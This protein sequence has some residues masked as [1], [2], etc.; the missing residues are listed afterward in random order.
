MNPQHSIRL[1][2]NKRQAKKSLFFSILLLVGF[3]FMSFPSENFIIRQL[4]MI[5]AVYYLISSVFQLRQLLTI[6]KPLIEI[7]AQ[8]IYERT[9]I[10][11]LN[12]IMWS[13]IEAITISGRKQLWANVILFHPQQFIQKQPSLIARLSMRYLKSGSFF[14]NATNTPIKISLENISIPSQNAVDLIE[15]HFSHY[16]KK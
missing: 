15:S 16:G 12:K 6:S 14:G 3:T 8:G 13:E 2:L 10:A 5:A 7:N 9:T 11:G 1:Y 4:T